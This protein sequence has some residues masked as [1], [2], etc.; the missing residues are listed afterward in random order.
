[1]FR[2]GIGFLF[3]AVLLFVATAG[4]TPITFFLEDGTFASGAT[5]SGTVVIDT[6]TGS[7]VSADLTYTLG[8]SSV[9]FDQAFYAQGTIPALYGLHFP[10]TYGGV[11]DGP[12]NP[13]ASP[14]V[15]DEFDPFL[16]V[17]S[18]VGYTGGPLCT[19]VSDYCGG[20]IG[21]TYYGRIN[22]PGDDEMYTGSL[23]STPEPSG[24]TL[25]FTGAALCAFVVLG[26]FRSKNNS[27]H[28]HVHL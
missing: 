18:L 13:L 21:S 6:A 2:L 24:F 5:M 12:G 23:V 27:A 10:V 14:P 17:A 11:V 16:P 4:A 20:G 7:F 1:M 26:R 9:T 22:F 28:H 15:V 8:G 25:T 19:Y 3:V